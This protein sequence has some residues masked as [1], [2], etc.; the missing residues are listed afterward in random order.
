MIKEKVTNHPDWKVNKA[1]SM[2]FD[3]KTVKAGDYAVFCRSP[4]AEYSGYNS[5]NMEQMVTDI[6]GRIY[7]PAVKLLSAM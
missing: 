4:M 1:A 7:C 5:V 6:D 3:D 2:M